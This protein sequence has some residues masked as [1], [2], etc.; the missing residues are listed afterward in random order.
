MRG[1]DAGWTVVTQASTPDESEAETDGSADDAPGDGPDDEAEEIVDVAEEADDGGPIP[2]GCIE[3]TFQPY[4]ANL[5]A[6][7]GNS[8]GAGSPP[9][10]YAYVSALS[11]SQRCRRLSAPSVPPNP[12]V[13]HRNSFRARRKLITPQTARTANWGPRVQTLWPWLITA[14]RASLSAVSGSARMKG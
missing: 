2:S 3:G 12:Q 13:V 9:E 6:H 14:R 4:F 8:D 7:T 5:H 11:A 1:I 10:A